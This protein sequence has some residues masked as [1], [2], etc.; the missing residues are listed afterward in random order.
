MNLLCCLN[1]GKNENINQLQLYKIEKDK[2]NISKK[3]ESKTK[4]NSKEIILENENNKH[5]I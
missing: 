1:F 2:N 3:N 5:F 4:K